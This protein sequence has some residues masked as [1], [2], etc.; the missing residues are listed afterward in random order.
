MYQLKSILFDPT[1]NRAHDISHTRP[2][3]LISQHRSV[4]SR[5]WTI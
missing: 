5:C 4:L 1:G 3:C 2:D